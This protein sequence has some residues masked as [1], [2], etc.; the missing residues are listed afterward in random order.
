MEGLKKVRE[1]WDIADKAESDLAS[2]I[3]DYEGKEVVV[4]GRKGAINYIDPANEC[5]KILFWDG[6]TELVGFERL[7]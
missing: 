2:Y 6:T 7:Y 4:D 1:L 3:S 5:A